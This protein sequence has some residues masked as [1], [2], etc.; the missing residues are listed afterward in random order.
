MKFLDKVMG[1]K[2]DKAVDQVVAEPTE[3]SVADDVVLTT[4]NGK[5]ITVGEIRNSN[6]INKSA[7][8]KQDLSWYIKWTASAFILTS[9][10]FRTQA[11]PGAP[12]E[13]LAFYNTMDQLLSFIGVCGWMAVG[14]LWQDRALILLN[15]VLLF[16]LASG[17][18]GK[19]IG[20]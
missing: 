17:L 16:V 20:A 13:T 5:T 9:A 18:L 6:R 4:P 3:T 8:P 15:G 19:F 1:L 7:T 14:F 12:L 10:L 2:K 11:D